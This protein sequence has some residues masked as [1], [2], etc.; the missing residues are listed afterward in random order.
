MGNGEVE[1]GKV[2]I[3]VVLEGLEITV[4]GEGSNG[5]VVVMVIVLRL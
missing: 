2:V 3:R 4:K 5:G 1:E